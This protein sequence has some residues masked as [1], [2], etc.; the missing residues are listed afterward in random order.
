M[1]RIIGIGPTRKDITLRALEAIK[2]SDI[3]IGYKKYI[4]SIEDLIEGK[5]IIKRGMGD[6]VDRVEMAI[7]KSFEGKDVAI[8]S[9]GDPGIY[10]M[11]NVFFQ[12]ESKYSN[13]EY[14]IIPGLTAA[15][16]GAAFLGAPLHD[17]ATIS[18]SDLLT[19][20]SEIKR[21]IEY[22]TKA[23]LIIAFYN[24]ISK[25]RKEPFRMAF[26]VLNKYRDSNT[27]VGLVRT[28][29][30]ETQVNIVSLSTLTEDMV[31]MS[32]VIIVGNSL[33]Y[34]QDGSMITPRGYVIKHSTHPLSEDFYTRF[35][36]GETPK[37]S[38]LG[39]EFH[40]CH[41][42]GQ[43]CTYCYC[44]F[45]PCGDGSTGGE[46]IK[47][48]NV[49]SCMNC[50]WIHTSEAV[51]C[52]DDKIFDYIESPEDLKTNKKSLLKLRRECLINSRLMDK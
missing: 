41:F 48:K 21:K 32:T 38:N 3:I 23:D 39:C 47:D 40:P 45:Y 44:P 20:L 18:L 24:P 52:I 42:D 29:G 14:E 51:K 15:N 6:E 7:E 25:T 9:S 30:D 37:G 8:V 17:F 43:D 13:I 33:T 22:S 36:N 2:N 1:I 19:P 16:Y 28:E 31:D 49:W 50:V 27:P 12:I 46:W 26:K 34:I 5:E 35:L 11:A 10:G 4:D